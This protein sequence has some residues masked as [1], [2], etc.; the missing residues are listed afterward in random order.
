[1]KQRPSGSGPG[2]SSRRTS[3]RLAGKTTPRVYPVPEGRLL[4]ARQELRPVFIGQM[5]MISER[6]NE[7]T[8]KRRSSPLASAARQSRTSMATAGR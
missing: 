1:M 6:G 2:T 3:L 4:T 8:E 5:E 7:V